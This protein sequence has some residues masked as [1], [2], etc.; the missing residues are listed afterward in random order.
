MP[1]GGGEGD[2]KSRFEKTGNLSPRDSYKSGPAVFLQEERVRSTLPLSFPAG[3][4]S[5]VYPAVEEP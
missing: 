4:E 5:Q 2:G 1:F 3:G